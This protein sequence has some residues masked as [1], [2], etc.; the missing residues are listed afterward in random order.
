MNIHSCDQRWTLVVVVDRASRQTWDGLGPSRCGRRLLRCAR[1]IHSMDPSS[2]KTLAE[3][4]SPSFQTPA[5][6]GAPACPCVPAARRCCHDDKAL[7]ARNPTAA[8][9]IATPGQNIAIAA[10]SAPPSLTPCAPT[11]QREAPPHNRCE[12]GFPAH[13]TGSASTTGLLSHPDASDADD[14]PRLVLHACGPTHHGR[15]T[16]AVGGCRS[17]EQP[18]QGP[19]ASRSSSPPPHP[20]PD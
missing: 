15:L 17:A 10:F 16:K 20:C 14:L 3:A 12:P 13:S 2:W 18:Q 8:A 4:S 9:A 6:L 1:R 7:L 5:A 11:T 19:R